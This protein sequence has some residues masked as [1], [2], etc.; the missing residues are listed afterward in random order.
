MFDWE[1]RKIVEMR[2][3]GAQKS[4]NGP[5]RPPLSANNSHRLSDDDRECNPH[6]RVGSQRTSEAMKTKT[7]SKGKGEMLSIY[8]PC[9]PLSY[10]GGGNEIM[11]QN[12]CILVMGARKDGIT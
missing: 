5:G 9:W 3:A 6:G 7:L 11:A 8:P 4:L 1:L 2:L 12:L 10:Y